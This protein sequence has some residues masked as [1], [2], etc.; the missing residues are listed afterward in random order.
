MHSA[1]IAPFHK[2]YPKS[3]FIID[4]NAMMRSMM[5]LGAN[6]A[7]LAV[8]GE[9]GTAQA[10]LARCTELEPDIVLLDLGLPDGDGLELLSQLKAH[11]PDSFIIIVSGR[12]DQN[13]V[14]A[15]VSRGAMGF[16]VKPF[17]IGSLT[18]SLVAARR[19]LAARQKA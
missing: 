12:N 6:E 13:V 11:L 16:I 5:R 18:D 17:S 7:E 9:A 15:A 3:V 19:R 10:A 8:L 1:T 2:Q 14:Q 4:D